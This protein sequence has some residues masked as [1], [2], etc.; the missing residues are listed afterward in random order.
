MDSYISIHALREEGDLACIQIEN[1]AD[2]FLSTPSARRAT[3]VAVETYQYDQ[4]SIHALREEGDGGLAGPPT[5]QFLSTPSARRATKSKVAVA[6]DV[7]ISIHAL[8][9]EGDLP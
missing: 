9:E 7:S 6:H 4:I 5:A 2:Q 3:D 1:G 8:R